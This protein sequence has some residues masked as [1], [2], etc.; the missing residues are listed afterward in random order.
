M[1]KTS[2]KINNADRLRSLILD[3]LAQNNQ[4]GLS[5]KGILQN[6]PANYAHRHAVKTELSQL[7]RE[8]LI[9]RK[10]KGYR[11][12]PKSKKTEAKNDRESLEG[13]AQKNKS[14]AL[15][16]SAN[17]KVVKVYPE[18]SKGALAGDKVRLQITQRRNN[19]TLIGRVIK[20]LE[21]GTSKILFQKNKGR[22]IP[23]T[24]MSLPLVLSPKFKKKKLEDNCWYIAL[25]TD[26][27]AT[28]H[29]EIDVLEKAST[30]Y[31]L[32]AQDLLAQYDIPIEFS[33]KIISSI[34]SSPNELCERLDITDQVCFTIDGATAKDF[35]DAISISK[36]GEDYKLGVHI[37]D[38]SH[39]VRPNSPLDECAKERGTSLYFPR[40]VIPMLP[41]QL[42]NHLC[43]LIPNENRHAMTCEMLFSSK[44]HLKKAWFYP[45]KIKSR[46]RFTYKQVQAIYE[47]KESH[48]YDSQIRDCYK[49][50]QALWYQRIQR[51]T[52]DFDMPEPQITLDENYNV[53]SIAPLQRVDAHK[54]IEEF[55]IAANVSMARF[56]AQQCIPAPFRYHGTP[57]AEIF[58]ELRLTLNSVGINTNKLELNSPK[59]FQN[60]LEQCK[61][62]I[63]PFVQPLILRS[64][65]QAVYSIE[66]SEHFGLALEYYCHFTSPI[67]RY[68]DLIVHRQMRQFII[69]NHLKL[70][71]PIYP[72]KIGY[73]KKLQ[74]PRL[75][76]ALKIA[77]KSSQLERRAVDL[78]RDYQQRKKVAFMRQY[79]N[80]EFLAQVSG[81]IKSGIFA[82]IPKFGV[83]G[84]I[85]ITEL[86]GYWEFNEQKSEFR[87]K[88]RTQNRLRPGDKL[89]VVVARASKDEARIDFKLSEEQYLK[90]EK[91]GRSSSK[92][93]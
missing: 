5:V 9:N 69:D 11:I 60:I 58:E 49:L 38:V 80:Q 70:P 40:L 62:D 54:M 50:Y 53:E 89:L 33:P 28:D 17:E 88:S 1:V 8:R 37:A 75:S 71:F 44:G 93:H 4:T 20:V 66:K 23:R 10:G 21:R 32:D 34:Q 47:G 12:N 29:I 48:H 87:Q 51:G 81:I 13:Y 7:L 43:S 65:Q 41:E 14:G 18:N 73:R 78:E 92:N 67:R 86:P 90:F 39:F 27:V 22:L 19:G 16:V 57:R 79:I 42:S 64:M 83:E 2:K 77:Q 72:F 85:S 56:C 68:P 91:L 26:K 15:I 84:F 30:R 52:I 61:E 76:Q 35:D 59:T 24:S 6:L 82:C 46:Q 25:P 74:S 36:Q 55:M 45:S 63:K 31:D 3:L